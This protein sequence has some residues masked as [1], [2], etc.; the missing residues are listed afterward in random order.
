MAFADEQRKGARVVVLG[1][2]N[3]SSHLLRALVPLLRNEE[4]A[5]LHSLVQMAD[6]GGS[7]GRLREQYHVG[8]M[9]DL[10]RCLLALSPLR[11]DIRGK[12]FIEALEYRFSSGDFEGHTLRNALLTAMELTSDLDAAI[13]TFARIL[14]I[15]KYSGV[16]PTTLTGTTQQVVAPSGEVLGEGEHFISHNV[17]AQQQAAWNPGDVVVKFKE[18]DLLLNP[19]AKEA[20]EQATHIIVAPGHTFGTILPALAS[21]NVDAGFSVKDTKGKILVVM[22]L[23]TTP[24]QTTDWS[25]ED[26]VRVYESY[27][28]RPADGVVANTGTAPVELVAGQ[29]WVE[30]SEDE[31]AYTLLSD[32][33]VSTEA[34]KPQPGDSVPRAIV[35]H[36]EEKLRAILAPLLT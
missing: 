7:T 2:G 33:L 17:D 3:G 35:V 26:F 32:E 13:A 34:Q 22:T 11:D 31:H 20:L 36:D 19:R 10:S 16:I 4:I 28:G 23:L 30:F 27:L 18:E 15:P 21:L 8:A 29:A 24:K 12:K 14:Q 25:G 6:D 1:G 5:S 9:G